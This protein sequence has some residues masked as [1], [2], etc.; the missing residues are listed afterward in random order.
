MPFPFRTLPPKA[1]RNLFLLSLVATVVLWLALNSFDQPLRTEAAPN[2]IVSFELAGSPAA[3]AAILASWSNDRARAAAGLSL[4]IDYLFLVSYSVLLALTV[5]FVAERIRPVVACV[6]LVG[7]PVVWLQ[8]VAG[9]LDAV[10]NVAL[11]RLLLGSSSSALPGVART[12]ALI[13]FGL[14]GAGFAYILIVAL[15]L[16]GARIFRGKKS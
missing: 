13:K 16:A 2:G 1:R 6:A 15:W 11:I 10:E 8:F 3:S 5:S 14:V 9:A 7:L 4:G 12:A